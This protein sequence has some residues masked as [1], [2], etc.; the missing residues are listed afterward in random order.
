[1]PVHGDFNRVSLYI[2]SNTYD[3]VSKYDILRSLKNHIT[4]KVKWQCPKDLQLTVLIMVQYQLEIW[5]SD[6]GRN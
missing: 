5:D 4:S 2:W 6:E 3:N 1:M